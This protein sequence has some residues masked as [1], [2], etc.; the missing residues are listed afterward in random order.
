MLLTIPVTPADSLLDALRIPGQIV[1]DDCVAELKVKPF[2]AGLGR[3]EYA[4]AGSEF[5]H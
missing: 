5:M 1:I 4:G 2:R 3:N